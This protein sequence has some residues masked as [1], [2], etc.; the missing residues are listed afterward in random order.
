LDKRLTERC[1]VLET[2]THTKILLQPE[3]FSVQHQQELPVS[4]HLPYNRTYHFV[5][6]VRLSGSEN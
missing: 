1:E 6:K 2:L 3:T 4:L 5:R